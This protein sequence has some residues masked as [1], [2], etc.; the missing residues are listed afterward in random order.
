VGL[1]VA[2]RAGPTISS[3]NVAIIYNTSSLLEP[4]RPS[5]PT[6]TTAPPLV[7][8]TTTAAPP[9][10]RKKRQAAPKPLFTSTTGTDDDTAVT[11][12]EKLLVFQVLN[13][14]RFFT[15]FLQPVY[16]FIELGEYRCSAV[17]AGAGGNDETQCA[18]SSSSGQA[19]PPVVVTV[20]YGDGSGEQVWTREDPRQLW[21]HVYQKP[22]RFWVVVTS[23][24]RILP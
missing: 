11:T 16:I 24:P 4:T 22:G 1:H 12:H 14:K 15:S 10:G 7:N 8:T 3:A 9:G 17:T 23:G 20:N 13:S 2:L 19:R 18:L 5:V 21:T 6:T